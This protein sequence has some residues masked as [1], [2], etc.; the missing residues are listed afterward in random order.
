MIKGYK[1][2]NANMTPSHPVHPVCDANL[3]YEVGKWYRIPQGKFDVYKFC[4]KA[5]DLFVYSSSTYGDPRI[6]EC[7]S[8]GNYKVQQV[9]YHHFIE[10]CEKIVGCRMCKDIERC[11]DI[12]ERDKILD[13]MKNCQKIIESGNN[14]YLAD[15]IRLTRELPAIEKA[16]LYDKLV[17][18]KDCCCRYIAAKYGRKQNLETLANDIEP[19]VKKLAQRKLSEY[20]GKT[21]E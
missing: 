8:D 15:S 17:T 19:S 7:E 21:D 11:N 10:D 5:E 4:D 13:E 14:L 16:E 18:H 12:Q 6:F 3:M 2:L 9:I 20:K 1:V